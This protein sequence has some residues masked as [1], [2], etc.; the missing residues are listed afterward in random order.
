[1]QHPGVRWCTAGAARPREHE[2]SIP[3][4]EILAMRLFYVL[5]GLVSLSTSVV[6]AVSLTEVDGVQFTTHAALA[7]LSGV[8]AASIARQ[9]VR[10]GGIPPALTRTFFQDPPG[11][12]IVPVGDPES[13]ARFEVVRSR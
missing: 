10:H 9:V 5:A 8:L 12:K 11:W 2:G 7:L 13:A 4:M 1:V 6:C 3:F